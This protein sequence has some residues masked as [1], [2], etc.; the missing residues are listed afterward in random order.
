MLYYILD[1]NYI[2]FPA[3]SSEKRKYIPIGF[4]DKNIIAS[5]ANFVIPDADLFLF[6]ITTV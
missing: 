3:V 2:L 4:L 5:A 6:G 1:T